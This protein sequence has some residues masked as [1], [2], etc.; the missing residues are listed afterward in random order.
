[1][2]LSSL[3]DLDWRRIS[4]WAL[5]GTVVMLVWLAMPTAKCSY[6]AFRD[7]PLSDYDAPP[8][9]PS[10][11]DRARVEEGKSFFGSWM[12][13]IK[14]CYKQ[15]PVM[16]QEPWK[17]DLLIGFSFVTVLGWAMHG[18]ERRKKRT[19]LGDRRR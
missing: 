17:A 2:A 16:G 8:E 3:F 18:L 11:A 7:I 4:R 5:L 19:T 10:S 6:A 14:Y 9:D 1:V 12:H 13:S 15:T